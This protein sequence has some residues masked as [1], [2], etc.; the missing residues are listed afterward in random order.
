M[1]YVRKRNDDYYTAG[2]DKCQAFFK[3]FYAPVLKEEGRNGISGKK[4]GKTFNKCVKYAH[5]AL[6]KK[7]RI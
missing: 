6:Q 3:F 2:F 4:D 7:K 1:S 5:N